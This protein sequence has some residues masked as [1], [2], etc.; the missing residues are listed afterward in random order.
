ML[1]VAALYWTLV[2]SAL[3]QDGA[4][5]IKPVLKMPAAEMPEP[6]VVPPRYNPRAPVP[7]TPYPKE[8]GKLCEQRVVTLLLSVG[9]NGDV[10]NAAVM[11]SS[12]IA[13]LDEAALA[14]AKTWK[15]LPATV[16]AKPAPMVRAFKIVFSPALYAPGKACYAP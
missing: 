16:N 12:N 6:I 3:A 5:V 10:T 1:P 9:S 7:L 13:V 4:Q 8:A 11:E 2:A 15:L 14:N